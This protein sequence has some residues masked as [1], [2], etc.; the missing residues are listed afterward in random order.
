MCGSS[1]CIFATVVFFVL[2]ANV[3]AI[4][5][6]AI[7]IYY[8]ASS[9]EIHYTCP[10]YFEKLYT[11]ANGN[12]I[13]YC[14]DIYNASYIIDSTMYYPD[15]TEGIIFLSVGFGIVTLSIIIILFTCL[16]ECICDFFRF[17]CR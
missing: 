9:N 12:D 2:A 1:E 17:C 11:K 10:D 5:L 15:N 3:A 4:A 8:T 14:R 13:L 7:G 16:S 6:I